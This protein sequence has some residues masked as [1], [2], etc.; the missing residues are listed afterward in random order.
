[1]RTV[2]Q[3]DATVFDLI[4]SFIAICTD[5]DDGNICIANWRALMKIK[6]IEKKKLVRQ[7]RL[8][9]PENVAKYILHEI[10]QNTKSSYFFSSTFCFNSLWSIEDKKYEDF[11]PR[12]HIGKN[13]Y[14]NKNA[15]WL[16]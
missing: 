14:T 6:I 9:F 2:S 11:F 5:T 15:M 1:M 8:G 13:M 10:C 12:Q 3:N 7:R 16:S 4:S